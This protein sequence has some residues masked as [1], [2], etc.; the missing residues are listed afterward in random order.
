MNKSELKNWVLN[1]SNSHIEA[2]IKVE[3]VLTGKNGLETLINEH[4]PN[5]SGNKEFLDFIAKD[6]TLVDNYQK[7]NFIELDYTN[8]DVP[9]DFDGGTFVG[10]NRNFNHFR[11]ISLDGTWYVICDNLGVLSEADMI[12][13]RQ[14][15]SGGEE[16]VKR[17]A[18]RTQPS[19]ITKG[20]RF[21]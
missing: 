1:E 7:E 2:W 6:S 16:A 5:L 14:R 15:K 17:M 4:I 12:V 8:G 19:L 9:Q 18:G 21:K 10:G 20:W 3:K 11:F 13:L